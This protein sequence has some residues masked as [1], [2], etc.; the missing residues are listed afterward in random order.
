MVIRPEIFLSSSGLTAGFSTRNGGVS[1]TPFSS[2]NLGLSTK[3][4]SEDVLE[5]RRRLF[6]SVGFSLDQLAIAGQV[7]GTECKVVEV[8]GLYPGFDAL[9]TRER[10]ILLCLSAADCA[11]VLIADEEAGVIGA[12][13]AGWRG[14]VGGIVGKTIAIMHSM[15]AR[16]PR[17][18]CY[19]S[20]CISKDN[21]EVGEEVAEQ[22]D[23]STVIRIEG[24][25]KPHID[26]KGAILSHL[27]QQGI[28]SSRIEVSP[29]CTYAETDLF[30]SHRAENGTTG[31]LMGFIGMNV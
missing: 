23:E 4:R 21:F 18:T 27:R 8:S 19:V 7:H 9:V 28:D 3:D 2:L 25:V 6:E 12:C 10:G 11:S 29:H 5:N 17:M 1:R 20:P 15:G 16:T 31:R 30:F 24:R 22:F 26:L 13:H 14:A